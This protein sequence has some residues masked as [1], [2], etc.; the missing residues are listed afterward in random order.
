M[1]AFSVISVKRTSSGRVRAAENDPVRDKI[2]IGA[3]SVTVPKV[4]LMVIAV[5]LISS[6]TPQLFRDLDLALSFS[7]PPSRHVRLAQLVMEL[8]L[9]GIDLYRTF[10]IVYSPRPITSL[11]QGFAQN[12]SRVGVFRPTLNDFSN[13]LEAALN[14]LAC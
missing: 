1:P 6:L 8:G 5:R 9:F 13:Q 7:L 2:T 3:S 11:K 4:N 12:V 10:Q 14:L